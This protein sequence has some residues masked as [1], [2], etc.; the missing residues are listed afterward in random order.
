MEK[1]KNRTAVLPTIMVG[2]EAYLSYQAVTDTVAA[3]LFPSHATDQIKVG[4]RV[5]HPAF[6]G[7]LTIT[8]IEQSYDYSTSPP[9]QWTDALTVDTGHRLKA[10]GERSR[11]IG[12]EQDVRLL[13]R[14]L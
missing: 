4:D 14:L 8:H 13:Q 9:T 1:R 12:D 2:G 10:C 7:F 3:F 11:T 5:T 6:I